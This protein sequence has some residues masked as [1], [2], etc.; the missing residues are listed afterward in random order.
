MGLVEKMTYFL[1]TATIQIEA[2]DQKEA[3]E[4]IQKI[5]DEGE[6]PDGSIVDNT[7]NI[8]AYRKK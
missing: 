7:F 1:F 8:Q 2:D 5:Q 4:I 3:E 6:F